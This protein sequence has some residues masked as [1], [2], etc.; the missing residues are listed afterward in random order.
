MDSEKQQAQSGGD[1]QAGRRFVYQDD[2]LLDK[3][4]DWV[5]VKRLG[6]YLKPYSKQIIPVIITMM[7]V[8]ALTKLLNPLLIAYAIDN[9]LRESAPRHGDT[10]L[11]LQCVAGMLTLYVI[12]WAANNYR[13]RFTNKVGQKVIYDL[14]HDLFK[15]IQSLSFRFFDKRPAGS[16]LVRITNYVNSLQDL[17]TNGVV[18]LMIDCVQ[19]IGIIFILLFYNV[20]LGLA[21]IVTV[22]VMFMVSTRLRVLIRRSWQ[23]VQTK[24]SRINAH[25]NEC[26]QGIKVTQA[27][28]QEKENMAFFDQMNLDNH[29]SWNRAS[30]LN[31]T[32]NPI[33]EVTGAIGYCILFWFGSHLIQQEEITVGLL[34]AFA[35]YIGHFW[36]PINR[37]GQMYSQMLIAMASSER[38]FE[39]IDEKPNVA[40][41]A[42]A[43]ALPK[44]QGNIELTKVEFEY[45]PGRKALKGIDLSV[46][47]GESI[48][49]VGH[50][51]SGK[52]TIINL[53]CRFYDITGG[54]I[55]IDGHDI[56]D[57]TVSSLRSQVGIVLQDT[58]IFSGTIRDN[59]RFGRLDATDDEVEFAAKAVR[60]HEFIVN[61]PQGYETEVQ[62]RGN[63]LSMGQRQL[64]SFAR[65]LL[66]DP[67]ILILDEA[68]ASIDTETELKIQEALKTLLAGRT[69][70][71][72]AHRLSTIRS[73]DKIIVLDHGVMME[74][75]THE[76][77]LA[78]KGIYYGLIQAQ[79]RFLREVG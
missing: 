40:E 24:Q 66:A 11:L 55:S 44:V 22:P 41:S 38:I 37:L 36:E 6:Q 42:S 18:N 54:S 78:Q 60:A 79:Y 27:F 32:F 50:T 16:I 67:R 58:F 39:F 62:E 74:Q 13:I 59:I 23:V 9:V 1:E 61:L 17:F 73:A 43:K 8:G 75:G 12:Q 63:V 30:M 69:S 49:L 10:T 76:E 71:I 53:L 28:T 52:S 70:F 34:V 77:L 7:I 15:N 25:L 47:A 56:R 33:I 68:T 51:G 57:V 31:Q 46:K 65:A 48:A 3:G 21:I 72:I 4:F 5:Q 19:L 64:I 2:E 20:K 45:E 14:R 29:K 26:I 35:T